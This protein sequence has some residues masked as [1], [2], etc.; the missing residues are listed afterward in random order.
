[1]FTYSFITWGILNSWIGNMRCTIMA[2]HQL[3]RLDLGERENRGY[4]PNFFGYWTTEQSPTK[5]FAYLGIKFALYF[6]HEKCIGNVTWQHKITV[7]ISSE[8]FYSLQVLLWFDLG[9]ILTIILTTE[10]KNNPIF[11]RCF[12]LWW[13]QKV[14]KLIFLR[15][16]TV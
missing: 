4:L 12:L 7:I 3:R 5:Y 2:Y 14:R 13:G 11:F 10:H 1:M 9:C 8:W 15:S 16:T 6:L